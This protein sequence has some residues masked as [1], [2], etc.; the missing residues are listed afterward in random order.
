MAA[1]GPQGRF[2]VRGSPVS[3]EL[4]L[5]LEGRAQDASVGGTRVPVPRPSSRVSHLQASC[6]ES[7]RR[8]CPAG[9]NRRVD[10]QKSSL[11]ASG[12]MGFLVIRRPSLWAMA[13]TRLVSL[14]LSARYKPFLLLASRRGST[15]RSFCGRAMRAAKAS[16]RLT[17]EE[18]VCGRSDLRSGFQ[19]RAMHP[20]E[21][22]HPRAV[23]F[24]YPRSAMEA[25]KARKLTVG[26]QR[27]HK[28]RG[29]FP[30]ISP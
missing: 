5:G 23:S 20:K 25:L 17:K 22:V 24:C 11:F 19:G 29:V 12:V 4:S 3:P 9:T 10:H 30:T 26:N 16:R 6:G 8:D 14:G 2:W 13:V 7:S 18:M 28:A 27:H 1:L 15:P 21:R